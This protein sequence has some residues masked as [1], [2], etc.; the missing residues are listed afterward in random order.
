MIL[1]KQAQRALLGYNP[2]SPRLMSARFQTKGGALTVIQ[3]YSPNTADDETKVDEFYDLLQEEINKT[4]KS[5]IMIVM[6]DLNAKVGKDNDQWENVM[7]KYGLGEANERGEK[8]LTFCATND[9]CISNTMYKQPKNSRQ[10]TW[11]SPDKRTHNK[12]DYIMINRKWKGCVTNARSFPSADVGSDHQLV[13]ANIKLKFKSKQNRNYPKKYDIFKLTNTETKHRYEVQIG[14]KFGP[15]LTDEETDV[16]TLWEGIKVA[17]GETSKELLGYKKSQKPKPWISDEVIRL[18]EERSRLKKDILPNPEKRPKY[19]FL[20]REIK[21]KT[22]GCKDS[23]LKDLCVKV[24]NANQATKTKEVYSTIKKITNKSTIRMQTVKSKDGVILTEMK[25][26]QN[27]WKETYEELYNKQNPIN[28]VFAETIPQMANMDN[29]PELLKEEISSA[30]RKLSDGKAPGY[31]NITAEELKA[32]GDTG[33]EILQQ[34]CNKIWKNEAFPDDWGKAIITPIYKK[35]D[36]LDCGNYRGISLLS[37]A[38]KIITTIIQRRMLKRAEEVISESQAGFRPGRSTVDQLFTLRQI[39]EKYRE[40]GKDLFCCYIDFEKAFDSV[41][42]EGVWKALRFFGF[43]AKIIRLLQSLY[44]KSKSAVRVNGDI[45][46]WFNTTVGVRQG[47]VI[48]PMLF[49]LLL[50]LVMLY[51]THDVDIGAT[52]QGHLITNL[53]FADD[54]VLLADDPTSLQALV[55]KVFQSSSDLGL[56]INILKTEV[57]TI[58][59]NEIQLDI[60]INGQQLKHVTKF[61]YLGGTIESKGTC[62]ADVKQRIGKALGAIQRLQPIWTAKDITLATKMELYRVLVLS[63]LLYGA[64]TWTLRKEDENR[65]LVFEMMCLRKILGVSRL[66]KIRNTKIR[67]TLNLK[68]TIIDQVNQKRMRFFGHIQ[69]MH[70][71]RYPKILLE[72]TIME[73]RPRGRPAKRW[74][75]CIKESCR[76]RNLTSMHEVARRAYDRDDWRSIMD[77]MA[78]QSVPPV[79]MP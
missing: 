61:V 36:K 11:E 51:A 50:E 79:P 35:K 7:G 56:K 48:S 23:W 19:N 52:I 43:S 72:A 45:T 25:D 3:V 13:L 57:Q 18:S 41:W 10:W 26:V 12:I 34:L 20:T 69:R 24:E 33:V 38:G 31:D 42:Q 46:E 4:P 47:C 59:R 44:S 65:L 27:R 17:I 40:K 68:H 54:I 9:L 39:T 74:M 1:N 29:E 37:H 67:Q 8:L 53:R 64:E 32:T 2:V 71:T 60:N 63:I 77:Q 22:K 15:L 16:N 14:G 62:Q 6:G 21:R 30:I 73:N 66:D 49:N 55:N 70:P 78:R 75:D 58:S 5:D 28:N 76:A